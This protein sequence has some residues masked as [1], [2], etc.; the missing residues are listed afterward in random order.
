MGLSFTG[1]SLCTCS[2]FL[3]QVLFLVVE[4]CVL[5]SSAKRLAAKAGCFLALPGGLDIML[6]TVKAT[7]LQHYNIKAWFTEV[8]RSLQEFEHF[9]VHDQTC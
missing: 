8:L 4:L 9:C 7:T 6:S 2:S 5:A 3:G 1:C